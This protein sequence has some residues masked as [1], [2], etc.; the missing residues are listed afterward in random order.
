MV[1]PFRARLPRVVLA[2]SQ[3]LSLPLA[4][5]PPRSRRS[6]LLSW[7]SPFVLSSPAGLFL[8]PSP[9]RQ[10][11]PLGSLQ[12][13]GFQNYC[14]GH[15]W[16]LHFW[17]VDGISSNLG[18]ETCQSLANKSTSCYKTALYSWSAHSSFFHLLSVHLLFLLLKWGLL[19]R[20][21]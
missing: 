4:R 21:G 6:F 16:P 12:T 11:A 3:A 1:R 15:F 8:S 5:G 18:E 13:L 17:G 14:T 10:S 20:L 7:V 2:Y 9:I 19:K